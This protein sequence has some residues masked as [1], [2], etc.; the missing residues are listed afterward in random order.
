MRLDVEI[1]CVYTVCQG[2]YF[3]EA[4]GANTEDPAVCMVRYALFCRKFITR[5]G[6]QKKKAILNK[7]SSWD[8]F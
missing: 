8:N 6:A 5:F 1:V 3:S 2:S 7:I 4:G